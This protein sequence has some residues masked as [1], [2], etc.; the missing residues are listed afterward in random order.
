M[1]EYLTTDECKDGYLYEIEARNFSLG[2]YRATTKGFIGIRYK[3]GN[4]YLFEELHWDNDPHFGTVKPL[5]ELEACHVWPVMDAKLEEDSKALF[6]Y[7]EG[8]LS[9][10][11]IIPNPRGR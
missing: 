9:D 8:Q 4:R 5:R 1:A 3:F 7:L 6:D 11:G 10:R 2:V